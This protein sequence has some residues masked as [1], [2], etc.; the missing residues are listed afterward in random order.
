M[1]TEQPVAGPGVLARSLVLLAVMIVFVVLDWTAR[2]IWAP[3]SELPPVTVVVLI[4]LGVLGS[5]GWLFVGKP[6]RDVSAMSIAS[7][8]ASGGLLIAA[9][10]FEVVV[11]LINWLRIPD[12]AKD[13]AVRGLV[14]ITFGG[15]MLCW[16]AYVVSAFAHR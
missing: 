4:T 13:H 11:R 14:A 10:V 7:N 3:P 6:A 1:V 12:A 8:S 5:A 16:N 15:L 2:F 9:V